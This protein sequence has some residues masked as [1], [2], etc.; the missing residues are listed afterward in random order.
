MRGAIR[1]LLRDQRGQTTSEYMLLLAVIVFQLVVIYYM[2]APALR[3][4]F[5]DLAQRIM[6]MKP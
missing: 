5:V 4:G 2:L 6:R 3:G 1:R